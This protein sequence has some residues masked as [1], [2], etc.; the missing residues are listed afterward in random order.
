MTFYAAEIPGE[1]IAVLIWDSKRVGIADH[2]IPRDN[3]T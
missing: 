1:A 3:K 2:D